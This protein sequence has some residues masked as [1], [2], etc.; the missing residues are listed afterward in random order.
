M[1]LDSTGTPGTSLDEQLELVWSNFYDRTPLLC[2][3]PEGQRITKSRP[4][5]VL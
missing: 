4:D 3:S 1:D 5:F 2:T